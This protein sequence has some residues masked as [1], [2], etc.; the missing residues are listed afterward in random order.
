MQKTRPKGE[1]LAVVTG[2]LVAAESGHADAAGQLRKARMFIA[3][4]GNYDWA[5]QIQRVVD[6]EARLAGKVSA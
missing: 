4:N 5:S 6:A 1:P 3:A 2:F